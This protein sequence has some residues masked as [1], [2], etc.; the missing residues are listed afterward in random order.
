MQLEE[1]VVQCRYPLFMTNQGT[2]NKSYNR[3]LARYENSVTRM[4]VI[5]QRVSLLEGLIADRTGVVVER[6][7]LAHTR[8]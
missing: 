5:A 7:V 4:D 3:P 8:C 2:Q 1:T 6:D